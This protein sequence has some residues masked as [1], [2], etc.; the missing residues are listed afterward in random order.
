[1]MMA[2][3]LLVFYC[4]GEDSLLPILTAI[5]RYYNLPNMFGNLCNTTVT[6][7]LIQA[8]ADLQLQW[9]DRSCAFKSRTYS[10]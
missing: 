7:I 2:V 1:M 9:Y 6:V 8:L 3:Y 10:N 4:K 5:S